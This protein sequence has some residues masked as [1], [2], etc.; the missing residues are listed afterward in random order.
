MAWAGYCQNNICRAGGCTSAGIYGVDGSVW[1]AHNLSPSGPEIKTLA[2]SFS[3][4]GVANLQ[5]KGI[6]IA[7]VKYM[8]LQAD[9]TGAVKGPA[10]ILGKT[11]TGGCVIQK[12]KTCIVVGVFDQTGTPGEANKTVSA[13]TEW[14][15]NSNY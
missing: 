11:K 8:F 15:I 10:T 2:G 9:I 4:A 5:A 14:L 3:D 13:F 7:G 1:G 12:A 6:H